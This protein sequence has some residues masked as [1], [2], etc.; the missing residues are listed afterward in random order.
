MKV[1]KR[2]H[3]L[4]ADALLG[5]FVARAAAHL[6]VVT[7][8][9]LEPLGERPAQVTPHH[10]TQPR[11]QI[12]C[13]A[14]EFQN[15]SL[16][17]DP[18]NAVK[19]FVIRHRESV[20]EHPGGPLDAVAQA[21]GFNSE[22]L[23]IGTVHRHRVG[24]VDQQRVRTELEHVLSD[25]EVR[26]RTP[27]KAE[28]AARSERVTDGLVHPVTPRNL[29]VMAVRLQTADLKRYDHVVRIC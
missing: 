1:P 19:N 29:D 10:L 5:T 25:L 8:V 17:I 12:L 28:N 7:P 27:Q 3:D 24:V 14:P 21:H 22:A 13:A 15:P 11:Q 4:G 2:R 9:G 6:A 16:V 23:E 18:R 26:G 20:R